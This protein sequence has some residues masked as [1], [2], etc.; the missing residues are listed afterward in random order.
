LV[1]NWFVDV[2]VFQFCRAIFWLAQNADDV[3]VPYCSTAEHVVYQYL[4]DPLW[5]RFQFHQETVDEV[6]DMKVVR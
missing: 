1:K 3:L 4:G 2:I 6:A 5:E